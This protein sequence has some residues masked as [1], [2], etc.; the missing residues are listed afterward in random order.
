MQIIEFRV[1]E[2]DRDGNHRQEP[3][4]FGILSIES[5]MKTGDIEKA[6]MAYDRLR[7]NRCRPRKVRY[8]NDEDSLA[9]AYRL[10][11]ISKTTY[12]RRLRALDQ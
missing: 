6:I 1:W 8:A 11:R 3:G 12:Y 2:T 10:G 9:T 5:G 4:E 7:L